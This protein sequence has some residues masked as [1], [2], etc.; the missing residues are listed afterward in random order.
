MEK[1]TRILIVD[2][3]ELVRKGLRAL[4]E[5]HKDVQVIGEA[6]DGD[7]AVSQ[8]SLLEPD[9]ILMDLHMPRKS[10]I[11][12]IAEIT[13]ANPRIHILVLTSFDGDD[14]VFPAIKA[15]AHG[16]LLKDSSPLELLQAIHDVHN[17]S[18]WMHPDIAIRVI[19]EMNA[20]KAMI[21]GLTKRETQVLVLLARGLSNQDISQELH[22]SERTVSTHVSNILEKL[23]LSNRTQAAL[24]AIKEGLT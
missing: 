15:G 12:A 7:E 18:S 2:D 22:I 6:C 4:M 3:H 14:M 20:H 10:G 17:G 5:S 23:H 19:R 13:K 8:A 21:E 9:I 1:P 16:Y 11:E 24:Y